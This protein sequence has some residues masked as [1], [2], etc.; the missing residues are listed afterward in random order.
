MY[1]S[2]LFG[3]TGKREGEGKEKKKKSTT[4]IKLLVWN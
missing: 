2:L 3:Q 1:T 4:W